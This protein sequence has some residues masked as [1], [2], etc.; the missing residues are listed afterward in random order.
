MPDLNRIESPVAIADALR[1]LPLEAP[2][3][4]AWPRL[5][6]KLALKREPPPRP[7]WPLS[8][9]AAAALAA[10]AV[11]PH[12]VGSAQPAAAPAQVAAAQIGALRQESARLEAMLALT[13][14]NE[15]YASG[16]ATLVS[17]QF[18]EQLQA[19]DVELAAT[20]DPS[21]AAAL[22]QDR[23]AVLR[24]YAGFEATRASLSAQGDTFDGALV[25]AY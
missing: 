10:V 12:W 15:Q 25:A 9:L 7:V 24:D 21:R 20:N 5:A 16:P 23:V 13:A 3:H 17:L 22:W 1:A 6:Q 4:S 11:L 19:L 18:E 8:L 14:E 2:E